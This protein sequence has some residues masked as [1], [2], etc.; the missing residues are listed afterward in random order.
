MNNKEIP[1]KIR[2]LRRIKGYSQFKLAELSDV[3][4]S[5]IAKIEQGKVPNL[6]VLMLRKIANGLDITLSDFFTDD[7][8]VTDSI[9]IKKIEE[10]PQEKRGDALKVIIQVLELMK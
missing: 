5:L 9:I 6:S 3:S 7:S 1:N 2:Q 4:D 10:L 8:T